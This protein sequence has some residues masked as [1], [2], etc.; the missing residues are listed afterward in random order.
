MEAPKNQT[1]ESKITEIAAA[2]T[3]VAT[4]TGFVALREKSLIIAAGI[5]SGLALGAFAFL[6]FRRN[7]KMS[8]QMALGVTVVVLLGTLG[9]GLFVDTNKVE[10]DD[11][12]P[13]IA[14]T[15]PTPY[16]TSQASPNTE[17]SSPA[18]SAPT[19][20]QPVFKGT[21]VK[22]VAREAI[23]LEAAKPNAKSSSQL[24][25]PADIF[26]DSL[27]FV[28]DQGGYLIQYKGDPGNAKE[29]CQELLE[30]GASRPAMFALPNLNYC[31]LTSED[32]IA[33]VRMSPSEHF[34]V[35][36]ISYQVWDK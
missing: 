7:D 13:S 12:Q 10:P 20:G 23:D 14:T 19:K 30:A 29:E 26:I 25:P 22:M 31:V 5:I 1:R 21:G 4:I 9:Y 15:T 35:G 8:G 32:R 11:P 33:L 6:A 2:L 28:Y 16:Q 36:G 18:P 27:S 24:E 3:I 17:E 34:R